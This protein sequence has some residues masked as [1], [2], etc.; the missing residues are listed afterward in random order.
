MLHLLSPPG[1]VNDS[2]RLLCENALRAPLRS[3]TVCWSIVIFYS[4][5]VL[6]LQNPM[7]D[8][9]ECQRLQL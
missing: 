3:W 2:G 1:F 7:L 9:H 5:L 6:L 8:V 4:Y